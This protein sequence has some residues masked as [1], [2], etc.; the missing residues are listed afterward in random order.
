M[1]DDVM[2][3]ENVA[4]SDTSNWRMISHVAACKKLV[5]ESGGQWQVPIVASRGS[6][7]VW[8]STTVHSARA[9]VRVE[10]PTLADPRLGWRAVVYVCYRPREEFTA[11]EL[12][13]RASVVKDN[14][15]TNHWGTKI[16]AKRPGATFRLKFHPKIEEYLQAPSKVYRFSALN[17]THEQKRLAGIFS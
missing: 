6:F 9:S 13:K 16:F 8:S 4:E 2:K 15:T 17:L 5:E 11:S 12:A 7:I 1:F 3:V 14:R 10:E